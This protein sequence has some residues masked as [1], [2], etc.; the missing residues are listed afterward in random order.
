MWDE[1]P[2]DHAVERSANTLEASCVT[3]DGSSLRADDVPFA[4]WWRTAAF[5]GTGSEAG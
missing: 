5:V 1:Q 4:C 2:V 3:V